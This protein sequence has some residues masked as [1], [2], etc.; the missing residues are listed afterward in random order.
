MTF[1]AVVFYTLTDFDSPQNNTNI[2]FETQFLLNCMICL[3]RVILNK[4]LHVKKSEINTNKNKCLE[5]KN[6]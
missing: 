6:K 4:Q 1:L 2:V 3:F 5:E